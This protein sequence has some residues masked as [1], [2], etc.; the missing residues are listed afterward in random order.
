MDLKELSAEQ[1]DDILQRFK[2]DWNRYGKV[3]VDENVLESAA[4]LVSAHSLKTLDSIQLASALDIRD[5]LEEPILF[6]SADK[7]LENAARLE[8]LSTHS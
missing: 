5:H 4:R 8:K 3:R 1:R 6:L 2:K 7:R